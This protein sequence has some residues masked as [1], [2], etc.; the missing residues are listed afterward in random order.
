MGSKKQKGLWAFIGGLSQPDKMPGWGFSI[1]AQKCKLGAVLAKISGSVCF[2]C[3]ALGGS[4]LWDVVANA[5]ERRFK[6]IEKAC[7]DGEAVYREKFITAF[8]L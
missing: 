5:L 2:G 4:Y 7:K 6:N 8:L 3:Y 1:P